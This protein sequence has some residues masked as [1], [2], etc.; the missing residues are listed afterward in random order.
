MMDAD[1]EEA[2]RM[3]YDGF[4]GVLTSTLPLTLTGALPDP[5]LLR[6]A[7]Q[8]VTRRRGW[9]IWVEACGTTIAPPAFPSPPLLTQ[10]RWSF[11]Y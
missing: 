10:M 9:C 11:F 6:Q 2:G 3:L 4:G 8:T 1:G 5:T 7:Q